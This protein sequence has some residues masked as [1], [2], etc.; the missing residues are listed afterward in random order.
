[1]QLTLL[2]VELRGIIDQYIILFVLANPAAE[3]RGTEFTSSTYTLTNPNNYAAFFSFFLG[4]M[5][6]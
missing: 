3:L 1:M 6:I 2:A 4:S 5:Q